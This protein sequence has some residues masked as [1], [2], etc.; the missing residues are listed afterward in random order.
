MSNND[1]S[2]QSRRHFLR[3]AA[4]T[5]GAVGASTLLPG[6][7]KN[8]LAVPAAR[9]TG[10]INDIEH[11]VILM[12]ENRSFDHY[13]GTLRG[14]RGFDD[15]RPINLPNGDPVWKQPKTTS[16]HVMPFRLDTIATGAHCM[17]DINHSWKGS[18]T[19]WRHFDE[20]VREKGPMCMGHFNRTDLPFYH[21]LAD[22][23]TVCDAWF[24]SVHGP[25]NPNR[26]HLFTGT[27]GLAVF[28]PGNHCVNN[29]DDGNWTANMASDNPSF[30]A[31]DWTTYAERLQNAGVSWRVYQEYDNYGDNSLAY[32]RNFRGISQNSPLYT[33]GRAWV[34]GSTSTNAYTARGEHLVAEFT[35][36]VQQGTL[37]QV[38]WI[39]PS[40]I[41]SEHPEAPPAFGEALIAQMLAALAS[42]PAVW[43]KTA[44]IITYDENGGFFDHIPSPI[45]P[46]TT[47]LGLSTVPT[48]TENHNNI[49]VGLGIR[50]P[51][52]IVSPWSKGGW[53]NSQVFDH[54]SV[55]RFLERRFGVM[56]PNIGSWRRAVTGDLTSAFDFSQADTNWP[57]LPDTSQYI[58][59]ADLSCQLAQ[60]TAP[61]NQ[62]LPM[63]EPGVR[64]A[65]KLPYEIQVNGR[66]ETSSGRYWLDF[67]NDGEAGV[68]LNVYS[69]N[70]TDGPWF[71]TL[72]SARQL[73]DYWSAQAATQGKYDLSVHGPNGFLREFKGDLSLVTAGGANLELTTLYDVDR[74][75]LML[76]LRNTGAA[77]C[78]ATLS[79]NRY[80]NAAPQEV[81]LAAGATADISWPVAASGH[82]YDLS[83]RCSGD[84]L[85]LR[86][87][88]GHM[89]TGAHSISDP[90]FGSRTDRLFVGDFETV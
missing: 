70:R 55:I 77:T 49:P 27:S 71:Y 18:H 35:R 88:A 14:V 31:F 60:P 36:D 26:M 43:S 52:L 53:V 82:W 54:T 59:N 63:Q 58:A 62:S 75:E 17:H 40:Y 30:N 5:A 45:P 23:F 80:S 69:G 10:T 46:L 7:I 81:A 16:G 44:F 2:V 13:F 78:T 67:H 86:R 84:P 56:E 39:V 74:G 8:A 48:A 33:R 3:L 83:I 68:A 15:P 37:P 65:R 9:R 87:I 51:T 12:Q 38:S 41:M 57:V 64:P 61:V 22:A 19:R 20:W 29:V 32:F 76:R 4:G 66:V 72:E 28:R 34:P 42:N 25:T 24:C 21:A 85:Y 47:A 11:V 73:A 50:V 79:A 89:E 1:R 6:V 90:A